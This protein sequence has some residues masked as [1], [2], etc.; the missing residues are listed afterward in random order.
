MHRVSDH[1]KK[2]THQSKGA[3]GIWSH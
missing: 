3:Q 1:I 2:T